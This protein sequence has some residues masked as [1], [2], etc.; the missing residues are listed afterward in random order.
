M[1]VAV[2][3]G[4][5]VGDAVGDDAVG[6]VARGAGVVVDAVVGTGVVL[7]VVGD[8]SVVVATRTV[9][10]IG[11]VFADV[12]VV[13]GGVGIVVGMVVVCDGIDVGVV[14]LIVL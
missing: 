3:T 2:G 7:T 6:G 9:E 11:I 1:V 10:W 13:G 5:G 8:D 14:I 4:S 12:I